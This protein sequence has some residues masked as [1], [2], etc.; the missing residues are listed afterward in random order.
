MSTMDI[1]K[2]ES[3]YPANFLDVGGKASA[4]TVAKGFEIILKDPNVKAI[5]VNI[6]GGIVRCDRI[7]NGIIE[8]TEKTEVKIPII[9]RLDGTNAKEA[10][11]ILERSSL[12]NIITASDLADAA[13]KAV[14][15]AKG[16]Q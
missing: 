14:K 4:N 2:L 3:G 12:S 9:V 5:L 13:R 10:S 1:I 15:A 7:A 8:A 16:V 6:F 11:K